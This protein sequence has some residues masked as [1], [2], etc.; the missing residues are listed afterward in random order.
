LKR[1]RAEYGGGHEVVGRITIEIEGDA[2]TVIAVIAFLAVAGAWISGARFVGGQSSSASLGMAAATAIALLR[3]CDH[4]VPPN[5]AGQMS[6][7]NGHADSGMADQLAGPAKPGGRLGAGAGMEYQGRKI[8]VNNIDMNVVVAGEGQDVLLVH[9]FPDTNKVWRHVIPAL[10]SAGYRLTGVP[11][12]RER[13]SHLSDHHAVNLIRHRP[14]PP[15]ARPAKGGC[16]AGS[17]RS[18]HAAP[19]PPAT[20]VSLNNMA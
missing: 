9:G 1:G 13:V 8:R 18:R 5:Q 11:G 14:P 19:A 6:Q 16:W 2:S 7:R 15:P 17:P 4:T 3:L 10:V 12:P 20:V